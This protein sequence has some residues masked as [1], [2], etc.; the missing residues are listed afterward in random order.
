VSEER[1]CRYCGSRNT[2]K[3]T[4]RTVFCLDCHICK[5]RTGRPQR[6]VSH[7][8]YPELKYAIK[9]NHPDAHLLAK[10]ED[11]EGAR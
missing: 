10:P 7:P 4:A 1:Q 8:L 2:K 6:M 5:G 9:R 3:N 11:E